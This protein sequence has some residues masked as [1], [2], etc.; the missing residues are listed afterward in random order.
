MLPFTRDV[1]GF[2]YRY[3]YEKAGDAAHPG[4]R[5]TA[6]VTVESD[7]GGAPGNP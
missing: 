3:F 2:D 6:H 4:N 1:W 5:G 7:D